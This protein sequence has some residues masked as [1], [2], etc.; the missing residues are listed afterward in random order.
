MGI[1]TVT[2]G[3]RLVYIFLH[4]VSMFPVTWCKYKLTHCKL[5]EVY[6]TI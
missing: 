5:F 6:S 4:L 1:V 3:V 2:E